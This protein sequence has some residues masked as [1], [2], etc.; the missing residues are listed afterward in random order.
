MSIFSIF[1]G[2]KL[3]VSWR[4]ETASA[5]AIVWKLLI[6][7]SG[8]LV[9]EERDVEAKTSSLFAIDVATGKTLWRNVKLDEVW[10]F[11]TELATPDRIYI[12]RFGKPDM[13]EPK[14][15]IV[16]DIRTGA[17]IW[18]Q[19]DV[20]M[21]FEVGEKMYVQREG[22]GRKEFFSVDSKTGE[23]L[24]AFGS[25]RTEI[26]ALRTLTNTNDSDSQYSVPITPDDE[27]FEPIGAILKDALE[28]TNLR[29]AIDYAEFANMIAFSY[30]ERIT[31]DPQAALGGLLRN[32]LRILDRDAG[33]IVYSDTV[34]T[35][36]PYPVPESFFITSDTLIYVKEKRE[37]IGIRLA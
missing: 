31:D 15:I 16:L 4:Y 2:N 36:T 22:F 10:W 23:I 13:P 29:G 5:N 1:K 7:P 3:K 27:L 17:I 6:S 14:G 8:I 18:E 11:N 20:A 25:D 33:D 12:H 34:A 28:V 19:P 30:H 26:L 37:I 32:E 9:G 35:Q 24:E 21:L